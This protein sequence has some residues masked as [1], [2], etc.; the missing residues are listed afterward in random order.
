MTRRGSLIYYFTA[1]ILGSF[2]MS[3]AVW[4][5][6]EWDFVRFS[7]RLLKFSAL[8][9]DYFFGLV[10]GAIPILI[11]A[12]L[13]RRVASMLKCKTPAHWAIFGAI[14]FPLFVGALETLG[15]LVPVAG[16]NVGWILNWTTSGPH[17][18][19]LTGWWLAIPAGA[20]TGYFL[21]RVQ[22]AFDPAQ[23]T[24]AGTNPASA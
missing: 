11:G 5:K 16:R 14:L 18:M 15:N 8:L 6:N 12:F 3:L 4:I 22:R 20:A 24:A 1:W 19:V 17:I 7:L 2:F 13:L 9:S 23:Q 10:L 21:G